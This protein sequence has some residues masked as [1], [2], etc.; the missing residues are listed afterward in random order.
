[1]NPI[2]SYALTPQLTR[3]AIIEIKQYRKFTERSKEPL[4]NA[5]AIFSAST[6]S[7]RYTEFISIF[8]P[9]NPVL[10]SYLGYPNH[11][12][13]SFHPSLANSRTT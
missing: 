13:A 11:V 10:I 9:N 4:T 7:C 5:D 8:L 1:V 3:D 2:P 6:L 12:L